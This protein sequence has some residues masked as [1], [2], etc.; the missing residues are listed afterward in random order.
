[1]NKTD[2][3]IISI[4]LLI[5][6]SSIANNEQG[7]KNEYEVE[8]SLKKNGWCEF[9]QERH[10]II[11][12]DIKT[13]EACV[14]LDSS[15]K[16][17]NYSWQNEKRSDSKEGK[18]VINDSEDEYSKNYY[19]TTKIGCENHDKNSLNSYHW[20][21]KKPV[22]Y[23]GEDHRGT[24][25]LV[26]EDISELCQDGQ[27]DRLCGRIKSYSLPEG[28]RFHLYEGPHFQGK[29]HI[30]SSDENND[31][32]N[33]ING[34]KI[35]S[36]KIS[37]N[38]PPLGNE[39][40]TTSS[41]IYFGE[42]KPTEFESCG[43]NGRILKKNEI[44][45]IGHMALCNEV[46]SPYAIWKIK[47]E[48]GNDASFMGKNYHCEMK[49]GVNSWAPAL[50]VMKT[51]TPENKAFLYKEETFRGRKAWE[52]KADIKVTGDN[53]ANSTI[54]SFTLG[55]EAKICGYPEP[56]Y[57][58]TLIEYSA[59]TAVLDVEMRSYKVIHINKI[60]E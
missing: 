4:S 51:I 16:G 43:E 42:Q 19:E 11:R 12:K 53:V 1:M 44:E 39:T 10:W 24:S 54:H 50:C 60:C 31:D 14:A 28:F 55:S 22:V 26:T 27:K 29:E 32:M 30:R 3:S 49:A 52:G 9:F 56:N 59:S 13:K 35:R 40:I 8:I 47:D 2:V 46:L 45:N 23:T 20:K 15:T 34:H 33:L 57:S 17:N 21:S 7:G 36:I 58:G 18:C 37:K 25:Y 38:T 48:N 5:S 6:F 41:Q